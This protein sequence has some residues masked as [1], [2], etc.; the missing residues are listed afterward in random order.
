M[1]E[2]DPFEDWR[3]DRANQPVPDGFAD[4]VMAALGDRVRESEA[5]AHAPVASGPGR[6]V[7]TSAFAAGAFAALACHATLVAAIWLAWA[8]TAQ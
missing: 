6:V 7:A 3:L 1:S 4:R 5:V 8:G 2:N